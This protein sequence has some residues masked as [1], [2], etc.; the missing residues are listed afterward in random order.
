MKNY[1]NNNC[2]YCEEI[3]NIQN[4]K[5]FSH[6]LDDDKI[7][8]EKSIIVPCETTIFKDKLIKFIEKLNGKKVKVQLES[9]GKLF[10]YNDFCNELVNASI[11][12]FIIHLNGPN[13]TVHDTTTNVHGSFHETLNGI[14]NLVELKQQVQIKIILGNKNYS[15]LLETLKLINT[16]GV[17]DVYIF[18]L[19]ELDRKLR[20]VTPIII[21]GV[22]FCTTNQILI[23][24]NKHERIIGFFTGSVFTGPKN[25]FIGII[26]ACNLNCIYCWN[27]SPLK[28]MDPNFYSQFNKQII[29][30]NKFKSIIDE[31]EQLKVTQIGIGGG[32]EP[33]AH[34]N[35]V[36]MIKY[37]KDKNIK[38]VVLTNGTLLN[39]KIIDNIVES[40]LDEI[41]INISAGS[42]ETYLKLHPNQSEET[43]RKL[44]TNLEYLSRIKKK[45][46]SSHPKIGVVNVMVHQNIFDIKN[47]I[48]LVKEIDAQFIFFK[49]VQIDNTFPQSLLLTK[50]NISKLKKD[51]KLIQNLLK[52][53]N[54][55]NS[56]KEFENDVLISGQDGL[57]RKKDIFSIP[58]SIGWT[59]SQIDT[60][61]DVSPCCSLI[62]VILG[63]IHD[64]Y[65]S[66]IWFSEKY[67]NFRRKL[68]SEQIFSEYPQCK[69]CQNYHYD[70]KPFY[71]ELERLKLLKFLD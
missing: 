38:L 48:N 49:P 54:I 59:Y 9:N 23:S 26:N 66:D 29:E 55:S 45:L 33:F 50:E 67:S 68:K 2:S 46:S 15:Y 3:K 41:L 1:C 58:C 62:N 17:K 24:F 32:G 19:E 30:F 40:K 20:E 16:V 69:Y 34:P 71:Y 43:F 61:G 6:I 64:K 25:V 18:F 31:L 47:M 63:N 8:N 22:N 21:E 65:F 10:F 42:L 51:S 39:R 4:T 36:D 28:E 60:N 13:S 53:T 12:K 57:Y 35:I 14:K 56:Y 70:N 44:I 52:E 37:V 27:H 7:I 11:E 5:I